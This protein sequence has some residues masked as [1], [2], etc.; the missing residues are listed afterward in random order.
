MPAYSQF[1][2]AKGYDADSQIT[3]FRAVKWGVDDE[4][5]TPITAAGENGVGVSQF[6]C[7]TAEIAKG[8][9]VTVMEDG[10]TEWEAGGV[11][12]RGAPVTVDNQGRCVT[13]AGQDFLWGYARQAAAQAG[14]RIAVSLEDVKNRLET[15]T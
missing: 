11:I 2:L 1:G 5:V 10:I 7:L 8:K 14:D 6:D 15:T 9:G 4:S 3:K 12:A 13:A